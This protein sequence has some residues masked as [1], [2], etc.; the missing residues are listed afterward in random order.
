MTDKINDEFKGNELV[1]E[2]INFIAKDKTLHP[3]TAQAWDA[4]K[5]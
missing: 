4:L 2:V 5:K 1:N 3:I